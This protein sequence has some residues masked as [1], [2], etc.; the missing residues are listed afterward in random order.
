[1]LHRILSIFTAAM[2]VS[3]IGWSQ[4]TRGTIVGRIT[5]PSGA[6]VAGAA[7]EVLNQAMG[8]TSR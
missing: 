6:V 5:D 2:A 3:A 8:P 4:E 1:M 7:V